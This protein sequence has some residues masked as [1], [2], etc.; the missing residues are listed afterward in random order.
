M[1]S[2]IILFETFYS[3]L[4]LL[5]QVLLVTDGNPGIGHGSL[6]QLLSDMNRQTDKSKNPVPFLFP[7]ELHVLLISSQSEL[8]TN[9]SLSL[10]Q[11][12]VDANGAGHVHT[13]GDG[14]LTLKSVQSMFTKYA[15]AH[16]STFNTILHCGNLN[17]E[18]QLFPRPKTTTVE[19][20]TETYTREIGGDI[21]VCGFLDM[22]DIASPPVLSRH[23]VIPLN[24][25]GSLLVV[26]FRLFQ[27]YVYFLDVF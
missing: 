24:P 21:H 14:A 16:Y 18:V 17:S 3:L 23:L 9:N 12:L 13:P 27:T 4:F 11:R 25:K 1:H 26:I 8:Q 6:R 10:Y 22:A 5:I 15:E 7:S 19:K 20:D 2:L